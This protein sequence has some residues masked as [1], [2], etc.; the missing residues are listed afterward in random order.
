LLDPDLGPAKREI[1]DE[2]H[3]LRGGAERVAS[4]F[5]AT[6]VSARKRMEAL[7]ESELAVRREQLVKRLGAQTERSP[8]REQLDALDR[9]IAD[10]HARLEKLASER[11]AFSGRHRDPGE[12]ARIESVEQMTIVQL[13]R[14]DAEREPLVGQVCVEMSRPAGLSG[15]ERV[16]LAL[17]DDQLLNHRRQY[18]AS[19][20]FDPS[21]MIV[22]ALGPRPENPGDA[23]LWNKGVEVI[24]AYRQRHRVTSLG[25]D[26]LGQKPRPGRDSIRLGE[27]Q[28]AQ[29]HLRRVQHGLKIERASVIERDATNIVR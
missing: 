6:E 28:E 15:A 16:E 24:Y 7:G 9:R 17:I 11:E 27:W 19:E 14:L 25:D 21:E 20:R 2:L 8:A 12:L 13:R 4:E 1:T 23:A 5:S 29:T 22:S 26:P 18:I 3:D 10:G